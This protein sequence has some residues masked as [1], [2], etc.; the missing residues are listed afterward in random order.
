MNYLEM[1]AK[2][3]QDE[4]E[5]LLAEYAAWQEKKISLDLS[6]GK[7]GSAQLD[8]SEEMLHV[9]A[10]AAE[11]LSE[12][13]FDCRNYGI[14][15]GLP[16]AKKLFADLLGIPASYIFVGGNSSL[17]LMYDAVARAML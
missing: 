4:R 3:L 17:N 8:L 1:S 14:V 16:E 10:D 15:D 6:R 13:G 9:P 5:K 11:C 12:A 2:Q 7:P